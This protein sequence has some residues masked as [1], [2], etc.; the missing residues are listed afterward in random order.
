MT[1]RLL[2]PGPGRRALLVDLDNILRT[3]GGDY[4]AAPSARAVLER[5]LARTGPVAY[6]LAM[7]PEHCIRRYAAELA[8]L[9]LRWACC[10][11]GPDVAD[12]DLCLVACDLVENGYDEI[13]V[14]SGDHYFACLSTIAA[15]TVVVPPGVPVARDLRSTATLVHAA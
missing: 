5:V 11:L 4:L 1:T 7:A 6:A 8:A 12:R 9:G 2:A 15:L 10:E 3:T 13:V 14:S